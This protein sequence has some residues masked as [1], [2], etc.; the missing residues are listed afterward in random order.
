MKYNGV[1]ENPMSSVYQQ[2]PNPGGSCAQYG[3]LG[4]GTRALGRAVPVRAE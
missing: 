2:V 4:Y 1:V 3:H